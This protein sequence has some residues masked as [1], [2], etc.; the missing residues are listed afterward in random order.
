MRGIEGKEE[1]GE[2]RR[3]K[4]KA[5]EE[6]RSGAQK[7]EAGKVVYMQKERCVA[8]GRR[9]WRGGRKKRKSSEEGGEEGGGEADG[10]GGSERG[11]TGV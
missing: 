10:R 2:A 4:E 8:G 6:R 7:P 5:E 3:W 9:G 1:A 11:S